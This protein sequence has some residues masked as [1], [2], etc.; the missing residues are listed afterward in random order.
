MSLLINLLVEEAKLQGI[1]T[2]PRE[3]IDS[4]LRS[5]DNE[6]NYTAK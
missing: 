2:K 1:E 4:L 6:V 5:W 3:E